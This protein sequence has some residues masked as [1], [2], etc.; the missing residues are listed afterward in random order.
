MKILRISPSD[1]YRTQQFLDLPIKIYRDI[2]QWVPPLSID[3]RRIFDRRRNPFYQHSEAAFFLALSA[4]GAAV[5]RLAILKNN[6][7]NQFNHQE[8]AF[9]Y[10]FECVHD[11]DASRALFE[12]GFDWARK[13]GLSK[14]LGP[15]GFSSLDGLGMLIHGF[16]HRPAFG[17][18]YNPAYYPELVESS[19]FTPHADIV[20]GCQP[21]GIP[22]KKFIHL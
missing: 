21:P 7:Y 16:E 3:V 5:G 4:D 11:L 18:P 6:H 19:G 8:V 10:L 2:S 9:F 15:H 1:R 12:A 22:R 13:S 14:I 20:S 17:I